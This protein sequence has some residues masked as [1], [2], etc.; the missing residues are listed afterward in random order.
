MFNIFNTLTNITVS[1]STNPFPYLFDGSWSATLSDPT[2]MNIVGITAVLGIIMSSIGYMILQPF[3]I[4]TG[5][6]STIIGVA[7]LFLTGV[8]F[9]T[10]IAQ[11]LQTWSKTTYDVELTYTEAEALLNQASIQLENGETI[12]LTQI[13]NEG[14]ILTTVENKELPVNSK[15]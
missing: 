12:I 15:N 13:E 3:L 1:S 11:E 10:N 7:G 4:M 9:E 8:I 6:I 5:T 2:L 14:Q